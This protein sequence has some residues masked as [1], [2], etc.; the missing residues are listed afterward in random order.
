M[1]TAEGCQFTG[2]SDSV[3]TRSLPFVLHVAVQWTEFEDISELDDGAGYFIKRGRLT[4]GLTITSH[5]CD[6]TFSDVD[7]VK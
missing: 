3:D 5:G 7:V 4:G 2:S 1:Q 6:L